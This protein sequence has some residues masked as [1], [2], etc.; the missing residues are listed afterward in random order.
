M[1]L[2]AALRNLAARL[3]RKFGTL[4][5]FR[6]ITQGAYNPATGK[7]GSTNT[8]T[9]VRGRLDDYADRELDNRIAAGDRKLTI[10]AIDL[11]YEPGTSDRVVIANVV[12][13]VI[14]VQRTLGV[15]DAVTFELQLRR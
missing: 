1:S 7:V 6:R 2:D 11:P 4:V 8:D 12:Y 5:V 14:R 9:N 15:N 3:F 10:A 13:D